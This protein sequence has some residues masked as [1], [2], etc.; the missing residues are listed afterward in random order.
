[1]SATVRVRIRCDV[2][3]GLDVDGLPVV[4]RAGETPWLD[5]ATAERLVAASAADWVQETP[6]PEPEPEA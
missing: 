2:A 5:A 1:M 3:A 6:A 4:F